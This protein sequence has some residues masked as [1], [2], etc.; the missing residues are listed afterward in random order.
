[1]FTVSAAGDYLPTYVV[2]KATNLYSEWVDG[3]P[4]GTRYNCTKSGWF[5][6]ACFED[7]FRTIILKWAKNLSGPKV[8]IGDNLSSHLNIEVV[9]L[10][11]KH[12]I[13]F[14]FLPPNSTHLTQPLD[15]A[16]FAPIKREWRKVLT[17][18]KIQNPGQSTVNRKHFPK[19]LI[20]LLKNINLR[21]SNNIKSGFRAA[22]IWPIN[23]RNVLKR[24]PEYFGEE[25][26]GLDS[27]LLDYLQKTSSSKP[28]AVKRSKKLRTEPGKSVCAA[29]ILL[30]TISNKSVQNK[31]A[32]QTVHFENYQDNFNDIETKRQDSEIN[33]SEA[34][35]TERDIEENGNTLDENELVF[36][37]KIGFSFKNTLKHI[38]TVQEIEYEGIVFPPHN[39][40][41]MPSTSNENYYTNISHVLYNPDSPR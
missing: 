25:V 32:K 38:E 4:D 1:M 22:G 23:A 7:Y 26:Y 31:K 33:I 41:E 21:E 14:V 36:N 8:I 17:N 10:C 9:E 19:L 12:D 2:Y 29:D 18:Y 16:F 24:T 30:K 39:S 34:V 28:M 6:S 37:D 40:N 27:D 11:Q 5:D 3:G 15:V 13:R 20:E 35:T